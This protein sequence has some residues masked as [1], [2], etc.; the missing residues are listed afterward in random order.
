MKIATV[1]EMRKIDKIALEKYGIPAILLMENAGREVCQAAEELFDGLQDKKICVLA[2]SGNNGGDA[3]AAARHM[4]NCGA[5]VKVFFTGN[6]AHMT[7]SAAQQRD[8]A[9]RMDIEIMPLEM[10]RDWDKFMVVLRFADGV[11]D[12]ILGTGFTGS[13]RED[14]VRL[15]H[16]VN[17]SGLPVLSIDMPSGVAA[18]TGQIGSEAVQAAVTLTLGLPKPGHFFA[19]GAAST[20]KLLVDGIGI[21]SAL[22][23]AEEIQQDFLDEVFAASLLPIRSMAAHKGTCGRL[24]VVAGSRGMTGAAAMAAA[25]I[26]RSGAGIATLAIAE[27]LHDI[28]EIKLTE[29]MTSPLPEIAPGILGLT[30]LPVLLELAGKYDAV[31]IG[32]GL[33]RHPE[34]F[35]SLLRRPIDPCFWMQMRCR[36]IVGGERI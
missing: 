1:N 11:I 28:M 23:T 7:A 34:M 22:L 6:A 3:F 35:G 8:I 9:L 24:L 19:P 4:A 26:L 15:I 20:G 25:A 21:P 31:L 10:E 12:G 5:R 16:C 33:G 2:G 29:V 17:D 14:I 27:S 36:P 32:P 18:D 13:L 30:A